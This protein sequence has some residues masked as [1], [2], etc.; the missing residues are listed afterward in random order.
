[1]TETAIPAQ[2]WAETVT[3]AMAE[4]AESTLGCDTATGGDDLAS[5]TGL[6]GSFVALVSGQNVVCVGF[7]ASHDGCRWIAGRMLGLEDA[8]VAE[9][10]HSDVRDSVGELVNILVGVVKTKLSGVDAGLTLGLPIYFEGSFEGDSHSRSMC[11]PCRVGD[12]TGVITLL[13]AAGSTRV[14]A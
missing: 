12:T 11:M 2:R 8:E 13:V 4:V 5:P 7:S 14:A 3:E 9:I 10:S 6:C 1:M